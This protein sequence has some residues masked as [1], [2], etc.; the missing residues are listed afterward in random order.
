MIHD[1]F[2]NL[3][4]SRQR[5]YQLRKRLEGKCESCGTRPLYKYKFCVECSEKYGYHGSHGFGLSIGETH[6]LNHFMVPLR[7]VVIE[8]MVVDGLCDK[9]VYEYLGDYWHGNPTVFSPS[10]MNTRAGKTYGELYR[11]TTERLS[12][13][14]RAGYTVKYVW[15]GDWRRFQLKKDP[16]LKIVTLSP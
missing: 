2:E 16:R 13:L 9:T 4:V 8:G 6:F 14:V 15:E 3:K 12:K 11:E 7:Q 1:K 10:K 5:K